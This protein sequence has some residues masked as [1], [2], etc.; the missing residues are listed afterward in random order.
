MIITVKGHQHSWLA[1]GY[2]LK[3][4]Q[5]NLEVVSMVF[6]WWIVAVLPSGCKLTPIF[7]TTPIRYEVMMLAYVKLV[8]K[9]IIPALTFHI[10]RQYNYRACKHWSRSKANRISYAF[11]S[12][13]IICLILLWSMPFKWITYAFPLHRLHKWLFLHTELTSEMVSEYVNPYIH[14]QTP[15]EYWSDP[16]LTPDWQSTL[17]VAWCL[18]WWF[19]SLEI[20]WSYMTPNVVTETSY[21]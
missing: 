17:C 10:C 5:L 6:T 11:I 7:I 15:E 14:T 12:H 1:G 20:V 21:H 3:I 19:A 16:M 13:S 8:I 2:N 4:G 18:I 9:S